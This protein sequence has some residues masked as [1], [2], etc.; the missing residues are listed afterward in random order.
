MDNKRVVMIFLILF[1]VFTSFGIF[2]RFF[3]FERTPSISGQSIE[4]LDGMSQT[5]EIYVAISGN[6]SNTGEIGDPLR[7]LEGARDKI[8]ELK[9]AGFIYPVDVYLR[10]GTYELD[11]TFDLT[12]QDSGNSNQ[13]ITYQSFPGEVAMISGGKRITGSWTEYNL[14]ISS[15][16]VGNLDFNSLYVNGKRA[17]RA[18]EPDVGFYQIKSVDENDK[19]HAFD[20]YSG[21]LNSGWKNLNDVEVLSYR[22]WEQSRFRIK[23][24]VND[25]VTFEG[26]L[27]NTTNYYTD[28][29][30]DWILGDDLNLSRYSVENVFEGLDSPGEWYLD[31]TDGILYYY[32]MLNQNINDLN[33]IYPVLEQ[34][35]DLSGQSPVMRNI[36][37]SDFSIS[38]WYKFPDGNINPYWSLIKGDGSQSQFERYTPGSMYGLTY[39]QK[40]FGI[41]HWTEDDPVKL[42]LL[43]NDGTSLITLPSNN[44]TRGEWT[45]FVWTVDRSTNLVKAYKN[46]VYVT[47][48]DISSLGDISSDEPLY[49]G[50]NFHTS[51]GYSGEMD[52]VRLFNSSLSDGEIAALYNQQ[53]VNENLVVSLSFEDDVNDS[54]NNGY[55]SSVYGNDVSYNNGVSGNG[56]SIVFD[57]YTFIG[58][59]SVMT[60]VHF[61]NLI[62]ANTDW[63]LEEG[64]DVGFPNGARTKSLPTIKYSFVRDSS[65]IN[66]IILNTGTT[67]IYVT[68]LSEDL[69]FQGNEMFGVGGGG[70]LIDTGANYITILDNTIY[71][72][73]VI[74]RQLTAIS[75]FLSGYNTI[76]YNHL[77]NLP[78][79]GMNIGWRWDVRD[80][81]ARNNTLEFNY[82]HDVMQE[83]H[84]GGG[85]HLLGK[86]SGTIFRNNLIHDIVLTSRHKYDDGL[87]GIYLDN[88]AKDISVKNNLIYRTA[89]ASLQIH[90]GFEN[91]IENNIFVDGGNEQLT[92]IGGR[93]VDVYSNTYPSGNRFSRNIVYFT[94]NNS[95][96]FEDKYLSGNYL[97]GGFMVNQSDYNLFY[98]PN[99]ENNS[100]W[101]LEKWKN[102]SGGDRNSLTIDPLFN[103]YSNDDFSLQSNSPALDLGFL[104]FDV[105]ST[106]SRVECT[107]DNDCSSGDVCYFTDCLSSIIAISSYVIASGG[108]ENGSV[109]EGDGG[110][111]GD[112]GGGSFSGAGGGGGSSGEDSISE[113]GSEN[114]RDSNSINNYEV[115]RELI[116]NGQ[117][118][119]SLD[120][121]FEDPDGSLWSKIVRFSKENVGFITI[122]IVN[123]LILVVISVRY[124][125][126]YLFD[127]VLK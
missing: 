71:E 73:A 107:Q 67:A 88:G 109:E 36:G 26:S 51:A 33:I 35:V 45:H 16:D 90:R 8:R 58:V 103:N 82:I 54:T 41:K 126:G 74:F 37:K 29:C 53:V 50:K 91:I 95:V 14:N 98:S 115:N 10:H 94:K 22:H 124:F 116:K 9:V 127:K 13:D 87:R 117:L 96:L 11:R 85:I 61:K 78:S 7:T 108:V 106:G 97:L 89:S 86:Q 25:K 21:N 119:D 121:V 76:S 123:L 31:K 100:N 66:S 81:P 5:L 24:I 69:L 2:L 12:Y 23:S 105:S 125:R 102:V 77:F 30:Y 59:S 3:D 32:P 20:F 46:G 1:V 79:S 57:G 122:L 42:S 17:V 4:L 65:F 55:V 34:L 113:D 104:E 63:D 93:I 27:R 72:I 56:R 28:R 80:T 52:E 111:G 99:F 101:N 47:Q 120:E 15:M 70:I 49:L 19:C 40:G 64:G 62:F 118:E 60:N 38:V 6:D 112:G 68:K 75:T 92:F 39:K 44:A 18:R 83:G 48:R 110:D 43:L 84:D 114:Y